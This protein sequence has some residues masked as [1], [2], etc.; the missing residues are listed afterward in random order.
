VLAHDKRSIS[1]MALRYALGH[2]ECPLSSIELLCQY[3]GASD[4]L[5]EAESTPSDHAGRWSTND[6]R[7]EC[8]PNSL[9]VCKD[10]IKP[11][12]PLQVAVEHFADQTVMSTLLGHGAD[13]R[14]LTEHQRK[15]DI[16]TRSLA[17][18]EEAERGSWKTV[19]LAALGRTWPQSIPSLQGL[20]R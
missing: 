14:L 20:F 19:V 10:S 2:T 6:S 13:P 5:E 1:R 17:Q 16:F 15:S 3:G 4:A 8:T 7:L 9:Y 11:M 18:L 12:T